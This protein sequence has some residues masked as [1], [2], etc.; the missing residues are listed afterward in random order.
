MPLLCH[1][2]QKKF[3]CPCKNATM[4]FDMHKNQEPTISKCWMIY[5]H[6]FKGQMT[7]AFSVFLMH[8][9][10][11]ESKMLNEAECLRAHLYKLG[12][13]ASLSLPTLWHLWKFPTASNPANMEHGQWTVWVCAWVQP[14]Y[15][16]PSTFP[17]YPL[18]LGCLLQRCCQPLRVTHSST[19]DFRCPEY[20]SSVVSCGFLQFWKSQYHRHARQ[21]W[22]SQFG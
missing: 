19:E 5:E 18:W 2:Q 20:V 7:T 15:M 13:T 9:L 14:V 16:Y 11:S 1:Q 17:S 22:L 12:L 6:I 8:F 10:Q 4:G 3:L 21:F